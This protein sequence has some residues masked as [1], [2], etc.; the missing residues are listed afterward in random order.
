MGAAHPRAGL[1][2][3]WGSML[4]SEPLSSPQIPL[5]MKRR[6]KELLSNLRGF[7]PATIQAYQVRETHLP[8]RATFS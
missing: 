5:L 6:P 8:P 1:Q 4:G 3:H 7:F 2:G